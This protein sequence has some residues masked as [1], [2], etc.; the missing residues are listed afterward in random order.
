MCAINL[1]QT[2]RRLDTRTLQHKNDFRLFTLNLHE[3]LTG[4][5][6]NFLWQVFCLKLDVTN[7]NNFFFQWQKHWKQMKMTK[8]SNKNKSKYKRDTIYG[9]IEKHPFERAHS[10]DQNDKCPAN[11]WWPLEQCPISAMLILIRTEW[12]DKIDWTGPSNAILNEIWN[13]RLPIDSFHSDLLSLL[14][15]NPFTSQLTT[16][17]LSHFAPNVPTYNKT[18]YNRY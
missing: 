2:L 18:P 16:L 6:G 3:I 13:V 9:W 4:F 11:R 14:L 1:E 15:N 7:Q 5:F 12:H 17:Q 10:K 8:K